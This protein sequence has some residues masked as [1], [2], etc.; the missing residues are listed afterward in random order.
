MC[1]IFAIIGTKPIDV[2][3]CYFDQLHL[4]RGPDN[5]S[6]KTLCNGEVLLHH[7]R[8]AIRDLNDTSNQPITSPCGRYS[9]VYNGEIYNTIHLIKKFGLKLAN[10][11]GDTVVLFELLKR[12]KLLSA[13]P[14]I[15]GMF[16]FVYID[17]V[18]KKGYFARDKYGEK[19]LYILKESNLLVL[20][21]TDDG[22]AKLIGIDSW[23]SEAILTSL[24]I[25][26]IV[27]GNSRFETIKKVEQFTVHEFNFSKSN[28]VIRSQNY[29][30]SSVI[31][32]TDIYEKMSPDEIVYTA[33][34]IILENIKS[35][36][37]S[38][39]GVGL[40]LSG[41]VDSALIAYGCKKM[42]FPLDLAITAGF[43]VQK[44]DE[45]KQA[46]YIAQSTGIKNHIV[47]FIDDDM[48]AKGFIE[49]SSKGNLCLDPAMVLLYII[50]T[51]VSGT[52]KCMLSG[53]GADELFDGYSIQNKAFS[54]LEKIRLPHGIK[55]APLLI[56]RY[57][58]YLLK[59]IS[60][61]GI[62]DTAVQHYMVQGLMLMSRGFSGYSLFCGMRSLSN[63]F[64][65]S[66]IR[67][68]QNVINKND[69]IH[70]FSGGHEKYELCSLETS[71]L[72]KTDLA[73]MA[74][75]V[76]SRSIFLEQKI[77]AMST[78]LAGR[79]SILL[80]D[81]LLLRMLLYKLSNN[82]Q[83]AYGK[84]KGFNPPLRLYM[85]GNH[86]KLVLAEVKSQK[87]WLEEVRVKTGIDA[88][89]IL[90]NYTTYPLS[91][92]RLLSIYLS[93]YSI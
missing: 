83:L 70:E 76:E 3:S 24:L 74:A 58:Q 65:D 18:E 2:D 22:I 75:S 1:G 26:Q 63:P 47:K 29:L 20:S 77:H 40:Y 37:I 56:F 15:D 5:Q 30:H 60:Y 87:H 54:T 93:T 48:F 39:R 71:L 16:A 90:N 52:V 85:G 86:M 89:F 61:M 44:Y 88:E 64:N 42:G 80:K 59:L 84:K 72:Q 14:E 67:D 36:F 45:S 35:R 50:S 57:A 13:L 41:G 32:A 38:E 82:K 31:S 33:E 7:A 53:D 51:E 62:K 81:K 55:I 25:G 17:A 27:P 69:Y 91:A 68:L 46:Q 66:Q 21:S 23:C 10:E 79:N 73:S 49:L 12:G 6:S 19:P 78:Q 11:T 92:F 28:I 34:K 9:M 43:R 8:L 4:S